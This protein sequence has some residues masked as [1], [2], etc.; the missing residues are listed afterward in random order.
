MQRPD[1]G[2]RRLILQV[3]AGHFATKPFHEVKLDHI[4]AEAKLGKGT[5]YIYFKSKEALYIA[6]ILD[7]VENLLRELQPKAAETAEG[8]AWDQIEGMVDALL[9]F[10]R[11]FPHLYALVR[12]GAE[13]ADP[14]LEEKRAEIATLCARVIRRG[15]RSGE[16]SDSHPELTAQ[17]LLSFVR[18]ALLYAPASLSVAA[19]RKHILRV[20]GRGIR[21]DTAHES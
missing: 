7:G 14:R 16:L 11:G 12:S 6:L 21:G 13:M 8:G 5:I 2:K 4:A 17:Y 3:A 1:E 19:L 10:G 15:V 18:V 9:A 20:L